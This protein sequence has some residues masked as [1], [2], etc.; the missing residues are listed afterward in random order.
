MAATRRDTKLEEKTRLDT[1]LEA[2]GAEFLVLGNL[3]IEGIEAHE[4]YRNAPGCDLIATSPMKGSSCRIQVKSRW[5]TDA[6]GFIINNL[7]SDFVIYVSL[8]RGYRYTKKRL[9]EA[10]QAPEF[11]VIPTA[12]VAKAKRATAFGNVYLRD[13][14]DLKK[15]LNRWELISEHLDR[16]RPRSP[17]AA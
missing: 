7:D 5:A 10:K 8:N 2:K 12:V 4:A 17:R 1:K 3:L 16:R 15:Y 9:A 13:F 14:R 11:Y 6:N